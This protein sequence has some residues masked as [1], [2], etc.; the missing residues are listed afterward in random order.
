MIGGNSY[1]DNNEYR[2]NYDI[3]ENDLI[4]KDVEE[5]TQY[6]DEEPNVDKDDDQLNPYDLGSLSSL[7]SSSSLDQNDRHSID[8]MDR[9]TPDEIAKI[10]CFYNSMGCFVYVCRS[11]V[12]LYQTKRDEYEMDSIEMDPV[13]EYRKYMLKRQQQLYPNSGASAASSGYFD[14]VFANPLNNSHSVNYMY[15]NTGVPVIVFNYGANPKKPKDLRILLAERATGF[16]LYE[17]K[18]DY[19]AKLIDN[20]SSNNT[21]HSR[22]MTMMQLRLNEVSSTTTGGSSLFAESM[23]YHNEYFERFFNTKNRQTQ[24]E[25]LFKF[26]FKKGT[27]ILSLRL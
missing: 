23:N 15:I 10:K 20:S 14:D 7:S 26:I 1:Y 8:S 16:C 19:I 18:F 5:E 13:N 17:F 21:S 9:L 25:H 22:I 4:K 24:K 2:E 27:N 11:Q 12:E 3:Y 6:V